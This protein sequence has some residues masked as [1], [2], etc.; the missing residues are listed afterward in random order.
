MCKLG[1]VDG[2]TVPATKSGESGQAS[3]LPRFGGRHHL[4]FEVV[5]FVAG[6]LLTKNGPA[7]LRLFDLNEDRQVVAHSP[8]L[9]VGRSVENPRFA[10]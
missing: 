1:G 9:A 5:A 8:L 6:A 3:Q 10:G 7:G 2:K 4:S